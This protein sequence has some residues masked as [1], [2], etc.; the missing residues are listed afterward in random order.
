MSTSSY[1]NVKFSRS[2]RSKVT[3]IFNDKDVVD[4]LTGFIINTMSFQL[5]KL[6][7]ISSLCAKHTR[8]VQKVLQ[9]LVFHRYKRLILAIF[10]MLE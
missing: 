9:M 4:I 3:S 1:R 2:M 8:G 6:P 5:T 7:I 10:V